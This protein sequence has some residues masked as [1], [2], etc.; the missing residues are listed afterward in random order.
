MSTSKIRY[1]RLKGWGQG[2]VSVAYHVFVGPD[3]C[4]MVYRRDE[5]WFNSVAYS[6][7]HVTR[8]AAADR[9]VT[10]KGYQRGPQ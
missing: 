9:L 8:H 6:V 1:K 7:P 3:Y 4:G 5:L 10:A 2:S